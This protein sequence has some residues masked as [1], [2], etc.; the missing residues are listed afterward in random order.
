MDSAYIFVNPGS[1]EC[2]MAYCYDTSC[3]LEAEGF[4]FIRIDTLDYAYGF[5]D[6]FGEVLSDLYDMLIKNG[7]HAIQSLLEHKNFRRHLCPP[8]Q[9]D[10]WTSKR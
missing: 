5:R 4:S 9:N 2:Q 3:I 1:P 7:Y 6:G 10:I 8:L